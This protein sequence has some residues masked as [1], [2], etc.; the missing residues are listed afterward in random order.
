MIYAMFAMVILT[1]IVG[2]VAITARIKS[3]R[4]KSMK[5]RSFKLM[6]GEMPEIV[7]K[8]TRNFNNQFELPT[9]FYVVAILNITATRPTALS[10]TLAWA[11]VVTR[12]AH[13][14]IHITRNHLLHRMT[15][16]WLGVFC[17]LGLWIDLVIRA[18]A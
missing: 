18:G 5:A 13:S 3:I 11:F 7:I 14:L 12:Y 9:L 10:L 2:G 1:T 4:N 17:V 15:A 16:F 6:D 8:T